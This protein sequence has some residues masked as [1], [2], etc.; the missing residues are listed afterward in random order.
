MSMMLIRA[1]KK[2]KRF[3][4]SISKIAALCEHFY[5]VSFCLESKIDSLAVALILLIKMVRMHVGILIVP[6]AICMQTLS[7]LRDLERQL[8]RMASPLIRS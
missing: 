8:H 7:F 4:A 3:Q 2:T 5:Y 1:N 6:F